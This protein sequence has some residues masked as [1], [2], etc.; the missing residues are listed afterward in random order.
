M[1]HNDNSS[2]PHLRNLLVFYQRGC[3]CQQ[4]CREIVI[5]YFF[6]IVRASYTILP[7][8]V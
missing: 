3:G 8:K 5:R 4:L 7:Q 6:L 1:H 2:I